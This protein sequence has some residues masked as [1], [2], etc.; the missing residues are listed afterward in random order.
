MTKIVIRVVV[1]IVLLASC[2]ASVL[3][4]GG[5]I[6]PLCMPKSCPVQNSGA[7]VLDLAR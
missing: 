7:L 5:G 3:A 1:T 6:P 4:D 2:P